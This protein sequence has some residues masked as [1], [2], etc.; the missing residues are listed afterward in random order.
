[1]G[2]GLYG[3][4]TGST[5]PALT[6]STGLTGLHG[7]LL[8]ALRALRAALAQWEGPD[9]LRLPD[10]SWTSLGPK[11]TSTGPNLDLKWPHTAIAPRTPGLVRQSVS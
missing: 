9:P 1:M 10:L 2:H 4:Y 6:G 8:L 3:L 11:N 7:P 5:A